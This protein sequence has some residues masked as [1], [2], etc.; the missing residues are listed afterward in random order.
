VAVPG[1]PVEDI[2]VLGHVEFVM[3]GGPVFKR[4]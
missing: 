3:K 1:N 4:P 2:G